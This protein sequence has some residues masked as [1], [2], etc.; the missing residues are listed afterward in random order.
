MQSLK[1][2]I[3]FKSPL[4]SDLHSDTIF[5]Q[6]CWVF[7][8]LFTINR[9]EEVLKDFK[10]KPFIVFSN[11][12]LK[13]HVAMPILKP[14]SIDDVEYENTKKFK[15]LQ[16]IDIKYLKSPLKA[17]DLLPALS[18][19]EEN[20]YQKQIL[21][22]NSIN[23]LTSTTIDGGLYQT[24]ETF[25]GENTKIDIY[26]KYDEGII[27]DKEIEEVFVNIGLMG[28]GKDKST[29]KGRFEVVSIT[30]NPSILEYKPTNTFVSLSCGVPCD[31][32]E[33][34]FGKTFTKFGKH[35]GFNI[36]NPFKKPVIL[37]KAG[38]TFK[39]KKEKP[40]FGLGLNL[41]SYETH[42]HSA[43]MLP[44]FINVEE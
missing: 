40:V 1:I 39:I 19:N 8:Y 10:Q 33:V 29:G 43:Y 38:S 15:K 20:Y 16:E 18:S 6:F 32:C 36:A 22:K 37:F 21:L 28:F 41:S 3:Q 2:T 17:K 34:L 27:T 7:G 4:A 42:M 25:F 12:F 23:R 5:G 14:L 31:D 35:G 24:V 44:L 30:K 26:S 9:L 11:G 13:N